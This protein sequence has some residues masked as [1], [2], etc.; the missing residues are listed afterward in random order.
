MAK[1]SPVL[2]DVHRTFIVTELACFATPTQAQEALKE[3]FG[4]TVSIQAI[5]HY[6]PTKKQGK[7]L[8]KRWKALFH[9][10][11]KGFLK[12]CEN[13]IPLANKAVRVRMLSKAAM[14]YEAMGNFPAMK[15]MLETIAKEMGGSY[16]NQRQFTGKDGGPIKTEDVTK[17]PTEQ[18]EAELR[19]Y[20]I[21]PDDISPASRQTH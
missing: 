8:G 21:D 9:D 13:Q 5:E 17:M 16:T 14:K 7:Q 15:D 12:H 11:R 3:Q 18:L 1:T 2:N 19:A 4:V 20:G 6:D 10:T